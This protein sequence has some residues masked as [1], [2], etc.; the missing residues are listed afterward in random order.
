MRLDA[1][2]NI[3]VP[4]KNL[5]KRAPGENLGRSG[6]SSG[7]QVKSEVPFYRKGQVSETGG[8][9]PVLFWGILHLP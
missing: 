7:D 3:S 4:D 5:I 2:E 9:G 1:V 8:E 6:P